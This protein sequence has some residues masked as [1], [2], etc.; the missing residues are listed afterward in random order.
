[1]V[2][3]FVSELCGSAADWSDSAVDWSV[4]AADEND[5]AAVWNDCIH[6]RMTQLGNK[7]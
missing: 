3:Y 6:D 1:M 5:S 4:L 2:N 7:I